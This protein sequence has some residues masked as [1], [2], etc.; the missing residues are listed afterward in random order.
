MWD[1][2][3][4]SP[5][6]LRDTRKRPRQAKQK[7][8]KLVADAVI[9]SGFVRPRPAVFVNQENKFKHYHAFKFASGDFLLTRSYRIT[10]RKVKGLRQIFEVSLVFQKNNP[11]DVPH[12]FTIEQRELKELEH[13]V[14][15]YIN[16]SKVLRRFVNGYVIPHLYRPPHGRMFIREMQKFQ[17]LVESS[18]HV[19]SH[20]MEPVESVNKNVNH[21]A[22]R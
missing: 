18:V 15:E 5:K 16:A 19:A 14:E 9:D 13:S 17:K 20:K 3:Y 22:V 12:C 10:P 1:P 6:W 11:K 4:L 2:S 7:L 8:E 21:H